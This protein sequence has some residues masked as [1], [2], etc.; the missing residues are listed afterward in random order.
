[1]NQ[2]IRYWHNNIE[3]NKALPSPEKEVRPGVLWGEFTAVFTPAYWLTQYW[4]NGFGENNFDITRKYCGDI[5]EETVFCLLGG[6][7]I[8]AETARAVFVEC[9]KN[10]MIEGMEESQEVW[11]EQLNK[12]YLVDGRYISYRFP[13][14]KAKYISNAIAKLKKMDKKLEGKRLRQQLMQIDGIGP[15]TAGWIVRNC[16]GSDEVAIIDIHIQ[17]AGQLC[18]LFDLTWTVSRHYWRMEEIFLDFCTQLQVKP[19][20]FDFL[21]WE[22]MRKMGMLA[23]DAVRRLMIKKDLATDSTLAYA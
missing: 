1:M 8:T 21:I 2:N 13:N 3:Y 23:T 11:R 17:R 7:G 9:Q 16:T 19:S 22:Q 15:K 10:D 4:M 14:K 20:I 12:K 6:Y 18:N 5:I